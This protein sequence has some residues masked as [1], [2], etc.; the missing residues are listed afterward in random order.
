MKKTL[1]I[2]LII[3]GIVMIAYTGF[4]YITTEKVVDLGPIEITKEKKH[5]VQW[6]PVVGVVLIAG[7]IVA[8]VVDKK[9]RS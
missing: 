5:A 4:N 3:V 2:V 1:G 6:P 7:G 8:I 9:A